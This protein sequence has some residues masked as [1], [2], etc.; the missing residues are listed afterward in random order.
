MGDQSNEVK[1]Q[2]SENEEDQSNAPL[3]GPMEG[4]PEEEAA[5]E[6]QRKELE[7]EL[8]DTEELL[9]SLQVSQLNQ[10]DELK[11]MKESMQKE[12]E[13]LK[14]EN[15]RME[16]Y[17]DLEKM[18][19]ILESTTDRVDHGELGGPL[20]DQTN[21]LSAEPSASEVMG[22][23]EKN[24][25]FEAELDEQMAAIQK[26][27]VAAKAQREEMEK[28]KRELQLEMEMFVKAEGA[29]APQGVPEAW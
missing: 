24:A 12:L 16:T 14:K 22:E 1:P 4:T 3:D 8:R 26:Q 5:L 17:A 15:W 9:R 2:T 21:V 7:A 23:I 19:N 28:K 20:K 13:A 27:L 11:N 6:Q 18:K 25:E 29:P 10:T